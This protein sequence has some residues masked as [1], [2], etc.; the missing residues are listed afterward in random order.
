M[1]Y[2]SPAKRRRPVEARQVGIKD[3]IEGMTQVVTTKQRLEVLSSLFDAIGYDSQTRMPSVDSNTLSSCV[4]MEIIH[5]L[6]LQLGFILRR[7]GSCREEIIQ[8]CKAIELFYRCCPDLVTSEEALRSRGSDLFFLLPEAFKRG[9]ILSVLSIWH[10]ISSSPFGTTLLLQSPVVLLCV[11]DVM[12][13]ENSEREVLMESLGLLK[14]VT[15]YGVEYRYRIMEQ[16]PGLLA[17]IASLPLHIDCEKVRER[18]SAVF[19]NLA[20]SP[21]AR[22]ALAQRPDVLTAISTLANSKSLTTTRNVLNTLLSLAVDGD[23]CL[24]MVFHGDGVI[25]NILKKYISMDDLSV[26]KRAARAL[27][28]V[29]RETS[30]P[31]MVHDNEL[32]KILSHRALHDSSSEVRSEAAEA[33]A[34]CASLVKAPS[35]QHEA[36]LDALTYLVSSPNTVPSEVM[37][38]VIKEQASLGPQNRRAMVERQTLMVAM[39]RIAMSP[40]SSISAKENIFSALLDLSDDE[41]NQPH[42]A[43]PLILDALVQNSGVRNYK[44]REYA[45]KTLIKLAGNASNRKSMANHTN[46]LQSLF[47]AATQ[48]GDLKTQVKAVILQLATEL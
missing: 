46:L 47:A 30:A 33:F 36:I 27:R 13:K 9:S 44:I 31:L 12:R 20:L 14:N 5:S 8:T 42:I 15:Y 11:R 35:S 28:L 26:R 41:N 6:C 4:D 32:M 16:P 21:E 17:T 2:Q 23:S 25:V 18:L 34:R 29:I 39:S 43:T 37:A 1:E 19:R 10:S 7:H 38:R 45:V 22:V 3:I 40:E 24:L 48:L